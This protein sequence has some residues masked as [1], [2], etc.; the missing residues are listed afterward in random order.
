MWRTLSCG[1]HTTPA[2]R[3]RAL[4]SLP[5]NR[6]SSI[7]F[8]LVFGV[9]PQLRTRARVPYG[10]DRWPVLAIGL[11]T[12][13]FRL[14]PTITAHRTPSHS[15]TL[16]S[17]PW[18]EVPRRQLARLG[19]DEESSQ[20]S[21]IALTVQNGDGRTISGGPTTI[22]CQERQPAKMPPSRRRAQVSF[23]VLWSG[24]A[25]G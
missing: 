12:S 11:D 2:S 10:P 18:G 15:L 6:L 8:P 19:R 17:L 3:R 4:R 23:L 20:E 7:L 14:F 22:L 24:I 5:A 1:S 25:V 16:F 13:L 21:I 9:A